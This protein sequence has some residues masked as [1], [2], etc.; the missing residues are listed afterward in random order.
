MSGYNA[1]LYLEWRT[2]LAQLRQLARAR[3][4]LLVYVLVLAYMVFILTQGRRGLPH[5]AHAASVY[6]VALWLLLLGLG[7]IGGRRRLLA[8]PADLALVVPSAI[9]PDRIV[10]WTLVRQAV[11]QLRLLVVVAVF[12]V[13]QMAA[14]GDV[15]WG[16]LLYGVGLALIA[17]MAI[18]YI[19]LGLGRWGRWLRYALLVLLTGLLLYA[20]LALLRDGTAG[21]AA[22]LA[23]TWPTRVSVAALHGQGP[24]LVILGVLAALSVAAMVMLAPNIVRRGVD[25]SALPVLA[26]RRG[27]FA[28]QQPALG[29]GVPSRA[30]RR[31]YRR[32]D[33]PGRG[34]FALFGVE[35]AR[36]YRT[37]WPLTAPLIVLGWVAACVAGAL[38]LPH[39]VPWEVVPGFVAYVMV[40]TGAAAASLNFGQILATPLWSQTPGPMGTKLLAWFMPSAL[41]TGVGWAG[42]ACGWL[43]GMGQGAIAVWSLP[44]ALGLMLMIRSVGLLGWALLP[45]AV[46]QRSIAVWLRFLITI[47]ATLIAAGF[48]AG[49]YALAG[50]AA[51]ALVGTLAA[52]GEGYLCLQISQLR[53]SGM[54]FVRPS[55]GRA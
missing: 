10:V 25:W 36:L 51:G 3:G 20:G 39:G 7:A 12:W 21:L 42:V 24:A 55:E 47:V 30:R 52:V 17:A 15:A 13:P 26:G 37:L 18:R 53:I 2:L 29:S 32:R 35:L 14:S 40:L 5:F 6:A 9:A 27:L 22:A 31:R 8:R 34:D 33:W 38:A 48:F 43:L 44:L 4:R 28:R 46:D 50:F 49:A 16:V 54:D 23:A 11:S 45:N 1:L 19:L 41:V